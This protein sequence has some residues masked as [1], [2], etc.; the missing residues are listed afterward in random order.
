MNPQSWKKLRPLL[1]VTLWAGS[2]VANTPPTVSTG[3]VQ[4]VVL[5]TSKTWLA[6]TASDPDGS[7]VSSQWIQTQGPSTATLTNA[8]SL[9]ATI[10]GLVQGAYIFQLTV[11]D[12]EGARQSAKAYVR[13]HPVPAGRGTVTEV[14]KASPSPGDYGHVVYLPPGYAVGTN[15][16]V[17]FFLHDT[18]RKGNG[19]PEELNH[20]REE[21]PFRYIDEEGKDFPFVLIAPQ[22]SINGEWNQYEAQ[23]YLGPFVSQIQAMY[24]V[25]PRRTYVA[26]MGLGGG[27]A[28][29]FAAVFPNKLAAI[30]AAAPKSWAGA[31]SIS[32][33][34]M[35]AGLSAWAIH[36]KND[37]AYRYEAT[38]SW[39]DQFGSALGAPFGV[40][41][42]YTAPLEN[43]TAFFRPES[44][45]WQWINGQTT[46]DTSGASP[47]RQVFFTIRN[48]GDQ[49]IC[50]AVYK[51]SN[52]WDWL[53][54]QRKP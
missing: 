47:T 18:G 53:L 34:M 24:K 37:T 10:S 1:L 28:L 14:Y 15:W 5:P 13:V 50:D 23:H 32:D 40:L 44:G 11:T 39:F 3:Q 20:V 48:P 52:V 29:N 9:T 46:T 31:Q 7:I 4:N 54:A 21:G 30:L 43:Q 6:G 8:S 17:V 16:P 51:D 19:G 27:G 36:G 26:G 12:N 25:D 2:A 45:G 38:A 42:H 33:G 35:N 22:T 41:T 49:F